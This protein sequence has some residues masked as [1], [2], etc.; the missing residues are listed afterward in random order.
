MTDETG[1]IA[2]VA[3]QGKTSRDILGGLIETRGAAGAAAQRVERG[4][5]APAG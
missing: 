2:M 4:D 3:L 5:A 1:E